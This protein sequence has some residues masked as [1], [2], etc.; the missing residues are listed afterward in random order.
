[1]VSEWRVVV[2][3]SR[4]LHWR[5]RF[6]PV[7]RCLTGWP[8]LQWE[9][10]NSRSPG[11]TGSEGR[12][13]ESLLPLDHCRR[14]IGA[15]FAASAVSSVQTAWKF[16]LCDVTKSDSALC[17]VV[18]WFKEPE[19]DVLVE[20]FC[21]TVINK[22]LNPLLRWDEMRGSGLGYKGCEAAPLWAEIRLLLNSNASNAS[23]F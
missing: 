14:R 15:F 2:C 13:S 3:E 19:P 11:V 8:R 23:H 4:T 9:P 12:A 16:A 10:W 22:E 1:M 17:L 5:T 21:G 7:C 6:G 18:S 20:H